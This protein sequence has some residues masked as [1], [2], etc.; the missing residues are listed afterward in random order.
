MKVDFTILSKCSSPRSVPPSE[1]VATEGFSCLVSR[2]ETTRIAVGA[3]HGCSFRS[4]SALKGPDNAR[5]NQLTVRPLQG[6]GTDVADVSVGFTHGYSGCSPS[7][8][9]Q[10]AGDG[11]D[12]KTCMTDRC[13]S[14]SSVQL[15]NDDASVKS[16]EEA[17]RRLLAIKGEPLFYSDWLRPLFLHYEID[18]ARLQPAVPFP[19]EMREGS[20]YVSLVAFTMHG[21]RPRFGGQLSKWLLQPI[22]THPLLN[23][24][25]YV[26]HRGESGIYFLSEWIPNRLSV[27][28]GPRTFGLPY[29][30]GR[31][32]YEHRHERGSLQGSVLANGGVLKYTAEIQRGHAFAPCAA[33]S[34]AEF[35]LE[36]YTAFTSHG[37][38]RKLFRIWHPPWLQTDVA[39]QIQDDSL[40]TAGFPWFHNARFAG[41]NYSPGAE[42]VWMGR[43]HRMSR[44]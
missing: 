27:L 20:A 44:N 14:L 3:T 1:A 37:S 41:A 10:P 31:L 42:H 40:L 29:R 18:P 34:L 24:R 30:H 12:A 39:A 21:L 8:R 38:R 9:R 7:G 28:L 2:R 15:R 22:A 35:L 13:Q 36:R 16:S 17:R 11:A 25:T 19:L 33:G 26:R 43:P 5:C 23:L 6:R 4:P 32:Q